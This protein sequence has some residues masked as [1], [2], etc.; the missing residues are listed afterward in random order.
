[1]LAL[2]KTKA[3][4][5]GR[6]SHCINLTRYQNTRQVN[7]C[8]C[9]LGQ[10]FGSIPRLSNSRRSSLFIQP[11]LLSSPSSFIAIC[12]RSDNSWSS[13]S[14]TTCRSFWLS[15]VDIG[16]HPYIFNLL[17]ANVHQ[18]IA[19]SKAKPGSVDALTGPLT[20]PLY[21]VTIMAT[22]NTI[23]ENA[24]TPD[25]K[26]L[27]TPCETFAIIHEMECLLSI[28]Q[29]INEINDPR[30]KSYLIDAADSIGTRILD[31]LNIRQEVEDDECRRE[32]MGAAS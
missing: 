17:L 4:M 14:C 8:N 24:I 3:T 32:A 12:K 15:L 21:E 11:A 23:T 28:I 1:M 10:F 16:I 26:S 31:N 18:C 5:P 30:K 13:R 2:N 9:H 25:V 20:K 7:A 6:L 27:P 19:S 22:K 29:S